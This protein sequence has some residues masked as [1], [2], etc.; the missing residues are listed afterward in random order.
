MEDLGF[1][2]LL[3]ERNLEPGEDPI[4][5]YTILSEIKTEADGWKNQSKKVEAELKQR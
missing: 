2:E 5:I 1:G 3:N 4:S